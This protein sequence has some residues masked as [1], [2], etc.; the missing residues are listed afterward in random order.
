MTRKPVPVEI[1]SKISINSKFVSK[2][3]KKSSRN[4]IVVLLWPKNGNDCK[5]WALRKS[6][7]TEW[8]KSLVIYS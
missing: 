3:Q 2:N 5:H 1:S 7:K 4:S 8:V 6:M